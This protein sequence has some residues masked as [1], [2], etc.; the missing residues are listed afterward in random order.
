MVRISSSVLALPVSALALSLSVPGVAA[1]ATL[2]QTSD[3]CIACHNGLVTPGGQDV[4]I[5]ANWRASIMANSA[6][7]PYWQASVRREVLDHP[8]ANA[9]IQDECST[10]HMPMLHYE[11][12]QHSRPAAVFDHLPLDGH[13]HDTRTAADGVSCSLCHQITPGNL[14]THAS[15]N[16]GFEIGAPVA[17]TRKEFGPFVVEPEVKRIMHSST[18]RFEPE[19]GNHIRS[20]ELCATCHTLHTHAL[21]AKGETEASL[22]EQVPYQEWLHSAYS[23]TQSCQS[24]HMPRVDEP[25]RISRVFGP[26]R[27]GMAQHSFVAANFFMQRML[28]TYREPLAVIAPAPELGAAAQ[29]TRAFLAGRSAQLLVRDAAFADGTLSFQV[30]VTN[31]GGHKLPTAYPSRRAWLHVRATGADGQVIFESG[32]LRPDGSIVGNDNDEDATHYEPHY[33]VIRKPE[34]VEIYE[35]ILGDAKGSVTTGL[36][37][38]VGYLK[39][40]RILPRGFDKHTAE[41]DIAVHGDAADDPDFT[42]QGDVIRFALPIGAGRS[43]VRITAELLCQPIGFR[44]A[45]NLGPYP[46]AETAR[47]GS[48]YGALAG[49]SAAVLARAEAGIPTNPSR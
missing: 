19:P 23:T 7:D 13:S 21:D 3:R 36:L 25:R 33:R 9:A 27:T 46:A 5:A 16:G 41:K 22:P 43:P 17:G 35:S 48:Y 4:S 30:Q 31:L 14:G 37:S 49:E 38:A 20:S 29:A 2:F 28:Q 12:R 44:W 42:D 18:V 32:A 39:D 15:F 45:K 6:R 34:Q 24:C 11:A 1:D 10:C 26:P 40:N 8:A 47:F